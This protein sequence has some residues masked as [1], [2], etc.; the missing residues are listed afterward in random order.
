MAGE[1]FV[2]HDGVGGLKEIEAVQTGGNGAE[3]RIPSLDAS[4]KLDQ[5][6]M[7]TGVGADTVTVPASENL[8]AGD[9][10]NLWDNAG[11]VNV[12]K[13]DATTV[14][15]E[16][17]GFVKVAVVTNN[18]AT[19]YVEGNNSALTGQSVGKHFL[20]TTAGQSTTTAPSSSGNIVQEVG[21]CTSAT[22]VSFEPS[23]SVELA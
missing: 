16:A 14:G 19:V 15:K 10:V 3:D 21:F 18:S 5:S 6:M 4:G 1:K 22:N 20:S 7:P 17:H 8:A 9:F 13:A 11:T 2:Q 12:R 23:K